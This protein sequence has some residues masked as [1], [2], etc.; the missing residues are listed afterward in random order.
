MLLYNLP[1]MAVKQPIVSASFNGIFYRYILNQPKKPGQAGEKRASE[2]TL[3]N[4]VICFIQ[5]G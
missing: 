3:I 4:R 2:L 5:Y 1:L